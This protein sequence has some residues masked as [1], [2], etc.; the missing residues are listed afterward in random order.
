MYHLRQFRDNARKFGVRSA[1]ATFIWNV[2]F[3]I[4]YFIGGFTRAR[5]DY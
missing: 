3:G 5:R 2:R 1:A 4:G